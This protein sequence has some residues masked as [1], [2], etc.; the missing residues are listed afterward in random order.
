MSPPMA[1]PRTQSP[2]RGVLRTHAQ[3]QPAF[4][5][6]T[7]QVH[8]SNPIYI[9]NSCSRTVSTTTTK[10][11]KIAHARKRPPTQPTLFEFLPAAFQKRYGDKSD[12][13]CNE[14]WGDTF[15]YKRD[16]TLRLWYTNP[17]GLGLNPT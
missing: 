3:N 6:A 9:P 1:Q 5:S 7:Q 13:I 15:T 11:I 16:S 17:C 12:D 4:P 8:N 2:V 10:R 14:H